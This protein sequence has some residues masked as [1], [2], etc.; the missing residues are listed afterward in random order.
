MLELYIPP[1]PGAWSRLS[2]KK[3]PVFDIWWEWRTLWDVSD[4]AG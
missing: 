4:I 3:Y 1:S 2:G